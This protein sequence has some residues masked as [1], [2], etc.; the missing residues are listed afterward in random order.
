MNTQS[1]REYLSN[2]EAANV[3]CEN[4]KDYDHDVAYLYQQDKPISQIQ[5][6]ISS[7][8][9]SVSLGEIYR[10]LKRSGISPSR[11]QRPYRQ[12]VVYFGNNGMGLE[13]ISHITGYSTR[14]IRNILQ[15][16]RDKNEPVVQS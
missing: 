15:Q 5:S 10:S 6:E 2:S 14:Q 13:E 1:F 9:G 3:L 8:Y 11:R 16:E 4:L 12:D 7:H